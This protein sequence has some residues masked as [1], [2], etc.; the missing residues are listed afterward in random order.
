MALEY[1]THISK[2]DRCSCAS[3]F[4]VQVTLIKPIDSEL[5]FCSIVHRFQNGYCNIN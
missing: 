3:F 1:V 4:L 5:T 2:S